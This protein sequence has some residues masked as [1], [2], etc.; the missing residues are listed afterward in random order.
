MEKS[1]NFIES[2]PQELCNMCAKCCRVVATVRSFEELNKLSQSG[3]KY[4]KDFLDI[5]EP[6]ESI[7]EAKKVCHK[8]V[9]NILSRLK[10]DK[11]DFDQ[12]QVG[13]YKCR[14]IKEN[15]L[16][17]I[18]EKRP[19]LC[20]NFPSVPWTLVPPGCGY[21]GWLFKKREEKKQYIRKLKEE[22]LSYE[23]MLKEINSEK[24]K[25]DIQEAI[26]KIKNIINIYAEYGS[27]NW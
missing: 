16:C 23:I 21:E 7:E 8:T 17:G 3:D 9:E 6:Y 2:R 22:L 5:F 10:Q 19:Q 4:S 24:R 20:I 15:N 12:S 14:Y 25:A 13:F 11:S 1:Q 18:Y 26:Q 27:E